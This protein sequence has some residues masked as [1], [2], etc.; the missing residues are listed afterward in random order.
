PASGTPGPAPA[1]VPGAPPWGTPLR[2]PAIDGR[3]F[4]TERSTVY[5]PHLNDHRLFGTVQVAG[6]SQTATV[7]SALSGD[8]G[9]VVLE[10]LHFPRALVLHDDERYEMQI[11][12][13]DGTAG[14]RAVS[15][16]SLLD[17]ETGRWQEHLTARRPAGNPVGHRE[18]PDP[19]AFAA[20]AERHLGGEAFYR[21]LRGIGYLLGPSFSWVKDAWIHGDEALIRFEPPAR[22]SEPAEEYAIHPGLLD[23]CLQSSVCFAVH[24][25]A[26]PAH[27]EPA[28]VIP[29]AAARVAFPGGSAAGRSLWG[30]V[31][32][33]L[34]PA[35]GTGFHQVERADL[36]LFD[37]SGATVLAMDGFRFRLASRSVL[38]AS[39]R[40]STPHTWDLVTREVPDPG[41]TTVDQAASRTVPDPG[42]DP[43]PASG[44]RPMSRT[45]S[46]P[47]PDPDS[48]PAP[49]VRPMSKTVSDPDP[50][51]A[52][53]SVD[54]TAS[55]T[56]AVVGA[57]TPAGRLL[58][59]ALGE[60]G[61][62]AVPTDGASPFPGHAPDLVLDARFLAAPPADPRAAT[63]AVLTLATTLRA[64]PAAVPYAVLAGAGV[65]EAPL[66]ET[67]WGLAAS[68]EAEQRE[69]R[70]LRVTLTDGW[71]ADRLLRTLERILDDGAVETRVET[72]PDGTRVSRLVPATGT[73]TPAGPLTGAALVTGGL[74]GLGLSTAAILARNGCADLTLMSRS[75]PDA[76]AR[77]A[78][79]ALT[80]SGTRVRVLRGDV[81][82]PGDCARA[83]AEATADQPLRRVLHLA[84]VTDDRAFDRVDRAA[85]ER[86]FAA[87]AL[88]ATTLAEAVRG[89]D[90][91]AFVLFSSASSVLGSAG[92]TV[93]AAANGYLNGLAERL[94]ARQT[95][96]ER[97]DPRRRWHHQPP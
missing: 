77:R 25:D 90:L 35:A 15:V 43:V 52:P 21:H 11:V 14:N 39:L 3:V 97:R 87:K 80:V 61:H 6:A 73:G 17:P 95:R 51:S 42:P 46:A 60:R 40:R 71:D 34:R 78:L 86:V 38:R 50:D 55:R 7:L 91:D 27:E 54:R 59:R 75:D 62:R 9:A 67:L 22:M 66:R 30:H 64:A 31:R 88:G 92:Q 94:R 84:G 82:D 58:T 89:H 18:A 16:Q 29:F 93:Y 76:A 44:V 19:R 2:S 57:A 49:G 48:G 32:A 53:A 69:R 81:T 23:S 37:D 83:V 65:P 13:R 20:R 63:E 47:D 26:E 33:D 8:G 24:D 4:V 70:L 28:L 74:G 85:A 12:E 5:P 1:T 36:H 96:R 72:G 56:V 79:D 68:L 41:A 45:V 10:D